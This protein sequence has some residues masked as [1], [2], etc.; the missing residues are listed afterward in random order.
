MGHRYW[1][2]GSLVVSPA[3]RQVTL[4][5][6]DEWEA[7]E[8]G[9]ITCPGECTRSPYRDVLEIIASLPEDCSICGSFMCFRDCDE[10]ESYFIIVPEGT[11]RDE[12][13]KKIYLDDQRKQLYMEHN[14]IT[15]LVSR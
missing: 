4:P 15:T 10:T 2:F 14:G 3:G 13:V 9:E 7:D 12:Q 11:T 1:V 6:G 5:D 8:N